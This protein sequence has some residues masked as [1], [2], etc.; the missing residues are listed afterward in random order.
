MKVG[1]GK[2]KDC[3]LAELFDKDFSYFKWLKNLES[4]DIDKSEFDKFDFDDE[5][6]VVYFGQHK[7][8]RVSDIYN[9]EKK[10]FSW[11]ASKQWDM[12]E[13]DRAINFYKN[14]DSVVQ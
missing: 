7:Y 11:L 10:Y 2:Y 4:C 12:P 5:D 9:N 8:R 14:L 13:L 1:F 6:C 3:T